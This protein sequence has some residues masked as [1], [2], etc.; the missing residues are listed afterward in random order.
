MKNGSTVSCLCDTFGCLVVTKINAILLLYHI[1]RGVCPIENL[2]MVFLLVLTLKVLSLCGQL[3][4]QSP[5]CIN[6]TI[7]FPFF[8]HEDAIE[9]DFRVPVF[10]FSCMKT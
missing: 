7:A 2:L 4:F 9:F 8:W 3:I 6:G 5:A 1:L 10:N